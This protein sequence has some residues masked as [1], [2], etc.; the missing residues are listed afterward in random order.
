MVLPEDY[1][2]SEQLHIFKEKIKTKYDI[3]IE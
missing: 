2:L 1:N 3:D